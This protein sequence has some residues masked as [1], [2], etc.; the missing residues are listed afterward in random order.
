MVV[1]GLWLML[2]GYEKFETVVGLGAGIPLS[3]EGNGTTDGAMVDVDWI[4]VMGLIFVAG[5][6]AMKEG[7]ARGFEVEGEND[8]WVETLGVQVTGD[9]SNGL[10]V[11]KVGG[12][13]ISAL[14]MVGDVFEGEELLVVTGEDF[15]TIG[16][17]SRFSGGFW[18]GFSR[19]CGGLLGDNILLELVGGAG[20]WTI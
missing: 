2:L 11:V 12:L 8:D 17:G 19:G 14:L 15:E 18:I 13:M 10:V 1:V 5:D 3:L 20:F 16:L 6:K 9:V 4:V 7:E